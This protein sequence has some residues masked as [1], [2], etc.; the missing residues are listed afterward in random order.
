MVRLFVDALT[1]NEKQYLLNKANLMQPIQMQLPQKQKNF[2]E[3]FFA[4]LKCI[5]NLNIFQKGMTLIADVSPRI[6]APKTVVR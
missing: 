3:L 5:L 2:P 4:F 1:A 6:R